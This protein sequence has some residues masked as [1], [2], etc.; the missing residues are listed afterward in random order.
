MGEAT[1]RSALESFDAK[2]GNKTRL[3]TLIFFKN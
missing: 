3:S 2:P 1:L